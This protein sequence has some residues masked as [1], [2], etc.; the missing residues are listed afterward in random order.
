MVASGMEA[1]RELVQIGATIGREFSCEVI[2]ALSP[3]EEET[4][5]AGLQQ[6]VNTELVYRRGLGS[7]AAYIYKH[8][9][10]QDAA[11]QSLL[12]SKRLQYHQQIAQV[13][14]ARFAETVVTQ[15]ERRDNC[16]KYLVEVGGELS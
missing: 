3:T 4:L 11:Y 5:Q 16:I 14:E 7:P 1:V 9:L 10:I 2:A 13:L 12:K 8:A 15:A 6:L